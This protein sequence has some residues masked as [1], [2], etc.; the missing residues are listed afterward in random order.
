MPLTNNKGE[1]LIESIVSILIFT[2]LI[3][4]VT[5]M[6][7]LSLRITHRGTDLATG[8]QNEFNQVMAHD[9]DDSEGLEEIEFT[10][11]WNGNIIGIVEQEVE[12]F[13]HGAFRTFSPV[14]ENSN[15]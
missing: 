10:I 7:L 1:T 14:T 4:S 11:N 6:I 9:E 2:V 13:E 12:M 15:D 3:A 5:M 8:I